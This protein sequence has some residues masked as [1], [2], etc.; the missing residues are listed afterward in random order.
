MNLGIN[1]NTLLLR[2]ISICPAVLMFPKMCFARE[3]GTIFL[4]YCATHVLVVRLTT[5]LRN[6]PHE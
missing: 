1:A 2:I 6:Y 5:F 3:K 4:E